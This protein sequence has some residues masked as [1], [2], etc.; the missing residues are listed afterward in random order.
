MD[1][2]LNYIKSFTALNKEAEH[3]VISLSKYAKFKKNEFLVKEGQFCNHLW[4]L[5]SGMVR[6]YYLNDSEEVTV[7]IHCENEILTSLDAYMH[8]G[9]SSE[10]LQACEDS[11]LI[12]VSRTASERLGH[13]PELEVFAKKLIEDQISQI[14]GISRYFNRMSAKEK[15]ETLRKIAPE[16]IKRAKLGHIASIMGVTQ[17]TLSRVRRKK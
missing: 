11:E 7:W 10:Y 6:K 9:P 1:L 3:A 8:Q 16:M 17:E 12:A 15:Y 4:Y 5:K 14:D 13:F 2:M